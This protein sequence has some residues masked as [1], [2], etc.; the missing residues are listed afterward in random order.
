[1]HPLVSA[2]VRLHPPVS[3]CI[4]LF[5]HGTVWKWLFVIGCTGGASLRLNHPP[6]QSRAIPIARHPNFPTSQLPDIPI[7]RHPNCRNIP[8]AR[9]F[10]SPTPRHAFFLSNWIFR[11]LW[12]VLGCKFAMYSLFLCSFILYPFILYSCFTSFILLYGYYSLLWLLSWLLEVI[13]QPLIKWMRSL[14]L[15]GLRS[16]SLIIET[17]F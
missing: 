1:M 13:K 11:T 4:R 8:I 7:A 5:L 10:Q 15:W 17:C 9:T 2:C 12:A 6:S 3:V 16:A 14:A